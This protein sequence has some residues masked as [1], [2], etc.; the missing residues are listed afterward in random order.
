[1]RRSPKEPI[2]NYVDS[3]KPTTS[4]RED[5]LHDEKNGSGTASLA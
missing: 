5:T 3:D 2:S 4:H 1:M